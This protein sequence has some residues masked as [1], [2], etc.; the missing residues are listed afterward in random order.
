MVPAVCFDAFI[1]IALASAI[2]VIRMTRIGFLRSSRLIVVAECL[3]DPSNCTNSLVPNEY[4]QRR[5]DLDDGERKTS[6]THE[7]RHVGTV[8]TF[9]RCLILAEKS[10]G[11]KCH[12]M[13]RKNFTMNEP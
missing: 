6:H 2:I 11:S 8:E 3:E 10:G 5:K 13:A 9:T 12:S 7:D 1:E 4:L